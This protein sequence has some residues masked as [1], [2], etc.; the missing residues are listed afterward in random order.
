M[1]LERQ[2]SCSQ[3]TRDNL[4]SRYLYHA[5]KA[6]RAYSNKDQVK[7]PSK[8]NSNSSSLEEGM[9]GVADENI[10]EETIVNQSNQG[11]TSN[12]GWTEEK[13]VELW[14]AKIFVEDRLR[15]IQDDYFYELLIFPCM[16]ICKKP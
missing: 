2:P 15:C 13:M 8:E 6:S 12:V 3:V 5:K 11:L 7:S 10:C 9:N 4:Y 14:K 16:R 1:W